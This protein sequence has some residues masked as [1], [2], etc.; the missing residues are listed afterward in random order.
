VDR[1]LDH[2]TELD[3]D[4]LF[5]GKELFL[6]G[7]MEHIEEAGI[8]SGD[9]ACVL[10]PVDLSDDSMREIREATEKIA[11]GVGVQG[12]VNIQFAIEEG[13]L[14][15][16]E[17]NPRASRT[18]PFVSKAIGVPLAKA[19]AQISLGKTISELRNE[20]LLPSEGDG[21]AR[22]ISVKEAVLPWNRFRKRDGSGVDALLGPEMRS[23]GEVMGRDSNLC[24]SARNSHHHNNFRV[25]RGS[26]SDGCSARRKLHSDFV[27]GV[28]TVSTNTNS[29]I[30]SDCEVISN[31]RVGAYQHL[32]LAAPGI[33]ERVRPGNFVAISV[34][35]SRSSMLLR[36]SF[37]IY[38]ST[39]RGPFGGTI[40]I[41]VAPHGAGSTW[42]SQRAPH[43]RLNV[44]GP[45]GN[46]FKIP[47]DPV[48]A[49]L[50]G[51]GYGS[52]PLFP[53][54]EILRQKNS[55]VE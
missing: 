24:G 17:A 30:Q 13:K 22:G 21:V 43:E 20:G 55:R 52:A 6:A 4:A 7:V 34:G 45:L 36:R 46:A 29:P 53:L 10:P 28:V 47:K 2:A 50:V 54:A 15:V 39:S 35:D 40:E 23:T 1:F 37:A 12:L 51:G 32:T 3:V 11:R 42:I 38:Q 41:I 44:V 8:H 19:A 31:R 33:S 18:V 16:L 48:R 25:T 9:S 27:A 49:L 5:D 26:R 14:F